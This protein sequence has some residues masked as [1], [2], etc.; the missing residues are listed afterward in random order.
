M[1]VTAQGGS[2]VVDFLPLKDWDNTPIDTHFLKVLS[3]KGS[4]QRKMIITKE[5]FKYQL[6]MYTE[7]H[8]Y[9]ITSSYMPR[10]LEARIRIIISNRKASRKIIRG[11][12]SMITKSDCRYYI[13]EIKGIAKNFDDKT[14]EKINNK[15]KSITA[16]KLK[17]MYYEL[18]SEIYGGDY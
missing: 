12:M 5:E 17:K 15:A 13:N 11:K 10:Q 16:S 14:E 7:K 1:E 18:L 3:F 9:E 8:K 4:T 6:K 2:M